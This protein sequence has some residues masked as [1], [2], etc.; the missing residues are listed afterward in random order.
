MPEEPTVNVTVREL[1]ADMKVELRADMAE[2]RGRIREGFDGVHTRLD[3]QNGR[4]RKVE[5]AQQLLDAV[6]AERRIRGL[7][8]ARNRIA[9]RD[10]VL[11]AVASMLGGGTVGLIVWLIQRSAG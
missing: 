10:A 11:V 2:V 8:N 3:S 1:L 4:L 6:Q 5:T 7:E 9:G